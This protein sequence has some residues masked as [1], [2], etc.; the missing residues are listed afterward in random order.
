[1]TENNWGRLCI[2]YHASWL[3]MGNPTHCTGQAD[4]LGFGTI[5]VDA[6]WRLPRKTP[7]WVFHAYILKGRCFPYG[8]S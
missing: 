4:S 3:T 6:P 2:I 8:R 1:M 7:V 5:R